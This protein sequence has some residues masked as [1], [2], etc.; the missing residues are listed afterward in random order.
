M[1]AYVAPT[2][3]APLRV[4]TPRRNISKSTYGGMLDNTVAGG[5]ASGMS[6]FETLVK[7]SEEEASLPESLI[8]EKAKS[9]GMLSYLYVRDERAG[10]E[11]GLFQPEVEYIYD[12]ELDEGVIPVPGDDEVQ[13]FHLLPLEEVCIYPPSPPRR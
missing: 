10:G 3:T 8:R 9:V 4:W 5:I 7:E 12:L 6:A 2:A 11:T 1:T 13:D